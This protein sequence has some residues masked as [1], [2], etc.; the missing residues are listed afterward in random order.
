MSECFH[1]NVLMPGALCNTMIDGCIKD[2][3][4]ASEQK[5]RLQA[6]FG[7]VFEDASKG[8]AGMDQ[9]MALYKRHWPS[10]ESWA[11]QA[12]LLVYKKQITFHAN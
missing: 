11:T 6:I 1:G 5:A 2:R 7:A 8:G 10:A 9:A 3:L 12:R 4:A